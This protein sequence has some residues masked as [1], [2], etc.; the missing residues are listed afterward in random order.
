MLYFCRETKARQWKRPTGPALTPAAAA[1]TA[2]EDTDG[3]LSFVLPVG[4]RELVDKKTGRTYYVN[5]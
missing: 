3:L 4:W 2:V 5:R 1:S